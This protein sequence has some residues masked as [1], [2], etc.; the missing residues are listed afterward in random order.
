MSRVAR[1]QTRRIS[2]LDIHSV[3][4]KLP[5]F[6]P[7]PTT[8]CSHQLGTPRPVRPI[9]RARL[10]LVGDTA[11]Q[12]EFDYLFVLLGLERRGKHFE[13]GVFPGFHLFP[14]AFTNL[15]DT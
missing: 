7:T 13:D 1:C 5:L 6:L 15:E 4:C 11:E 8:G 12:S 10:Q 2:P 3:V 14:H 9:L